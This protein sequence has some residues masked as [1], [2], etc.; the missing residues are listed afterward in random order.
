MLVKRIFSYCLVSFIFSVRKLRAEIWV[1]LQ[2]L[3]IHR[4][5][6]R[7]IFSSLLVYLFSLF[8]WVF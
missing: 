2:E 1:P 6:L 8:Q 3:S 4:S 5:L 7:D